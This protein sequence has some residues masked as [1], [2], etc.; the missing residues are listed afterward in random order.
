MSHAWHS[1]LYV[2]LRYHEHKTLPGR[3]R[4]TWKNNI[5]ILLKEIGWDGAN[6]INLAQDR[7]QWR[8]IVKTIM[9]IRVLITGNFFSS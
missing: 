6:W 3:V 9:N 1:F 8:V 2:T 4:F 5:K 7:Y